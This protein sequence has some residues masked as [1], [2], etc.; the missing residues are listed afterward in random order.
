MLD[1]PCVAGETYREPV[2]DILMGRGS[3]PGPTPRAKFYSASNV[4]DLFPGRSTP[5]ALHKNA[6]WQFKSITVPG[7]SSELELVYDMTLQQLRSLGMERFPVIE[8][9]EQELTLDMVEDMARLWPAPV[10]EPHVT[11]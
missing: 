5:T 6:W 3:A 4:V 11:L 9:H 2:K 7:E 8:G 1:C 10:E